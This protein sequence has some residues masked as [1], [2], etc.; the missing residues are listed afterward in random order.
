MINGTGL[1]Q[2][3]RGIETEKRIKEYIVKNPSALK[4]D[5]CEAM[6]ITPTTLRKYLKRINAKKAG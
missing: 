1:H 6:A 3:I 2:K 5:V 4:K